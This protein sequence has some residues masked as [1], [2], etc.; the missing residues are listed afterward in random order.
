[1]TLRPRAGSR[2]QTA[3]S[4]MAVNGHFSSVGDTGVADYEHG[5]QVIDEEKEFKYSLPVFHLRPP[6]S[7]RRM[8]RKNLFYYHIFCNVS[9]GDVRSYQY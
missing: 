9:E 1:M 5:V 8:D 2:S 4:K 3:P 6:S 7:L